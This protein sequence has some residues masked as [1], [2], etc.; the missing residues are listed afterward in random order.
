[1]D[2]LRSTLLMASLHMF[3]S[4][5]VYFY[6]ASWTRGRLKMLKVTITTA[7]VFLCC[8]CRTGSD[9]FRTFV[10]MAALKHLTNMMPVPSRTVHP[11][12][13]SGMFWVSKIR[14]PK[15]S[16]IENAFVF[17]PSMSLPYCEPLPQLH[18]D[19]TISKSSI[20]ACCS[21]PGAQLVESTAHD[22]VGT[23]VGLFNGPWYYI[24]IS[25]LIYW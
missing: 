21:K 12:A 15:W 22:F 23:E 8:F 6:L 25:S 16:E 17:S 9:A 19:A 10:L 5:L 11:Q 7:V 13:G 24:C 1:M 14:L 18:A 2:S 4:K 3:Q 20:S